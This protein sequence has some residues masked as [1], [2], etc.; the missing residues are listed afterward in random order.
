MDRSTPRLEFRHV[1]C[2]RV[3]V[4]TDSSFIDETSNGQGPFDLTFATTIF[5]WFDFE[6]G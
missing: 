2:H 5:D 1:G 3:L 4:L 6:A